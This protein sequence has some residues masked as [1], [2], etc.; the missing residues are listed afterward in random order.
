MG[1]VLGT[2]QDKFREKFNG[3]EWREEQIRKISDKVFD[4]LREESG[5]DRLTFEDVYIAI[6]TVFNDMN[7]RLPGPH[8][9]P[10]SKA[11]V[12]ALMKEHDVNLDG[13]LNREEFAAFI[14]KL[15]ADT[16]TT[17]GQNLIVAL[18]I[19]PAVALITKRATEGVPGVGTVVQ[20]IPN[21]IYASAVALAVVFLQNSAA[22]AS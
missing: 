12:M 21:S 1:Q 13:L 6:L 7:K 5:R 8:Y 9:D 18:L 3:K 11:T 14:R 10:P 15:T 19:A 17:V 16:L 4:R 20:R 22:E 2:A